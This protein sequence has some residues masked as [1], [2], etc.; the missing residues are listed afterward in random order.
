MNFWEHRTTNI[1]RRTLNRGTIPVLFVIFALFLATVSDS[2]AQVESGLTNAAILSNAPLQSIAAELGLPLLETTMTNLPGATTN[3][4]G[5]WAGVQM[6]LNLARGQRLGKETDLATK[7]LI[8]I[9]QENAPPEL[10]RLA[11][12]ELALVTQ[13]TGDFVKAQQIYAQYLQRY[14]DDPNGPDVLL[15]QGLLYRQMGVTG[16]AISKFYAVMSSSLRLQ[17]DNMDYY[18]KLVV[19]AQMEIADTYYLEGKY[20]ESADFFTRLAR[21]G[22]AGT[23][24]AQIQFKLIRSLSYL[25]NY[26][27]TVARA[28]VFLQTYT[29]SPDVPEIRFLL[30]SALKSMGRNQD[31]MKQVMLLLQSQEAN[32]KKNPETWIYWQ[33]RAGNGIANELYKE[34][35]YFSALQIYQTLANLDKSPSWQLPVW[36]QIGLVYEQLQQPQK[37]IDTYLRIIDRRKETGTNASPALLSLFDMANWRKDYV[38]WMEKARITNKTFERREATEQT[39]AAKP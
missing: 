5:A 28:Q 39:V 33:Q 7:T 1:E 26:V 16:M 37:A 20:S 23:N 11:L 4:S 27:D 14:P 6:E 3:S 15:R 13:D 21:D 8:R 24:A 22:Y 9:L 2:K 17:T 34:G 30:A 25:T 31:A 18:K 29:N 19:R 12:L 36:Y 38:A 35:D 32:V 10:K